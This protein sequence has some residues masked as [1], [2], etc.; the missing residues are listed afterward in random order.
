MAVKK[1]E[2]HH[3]HIEPNHDG[4]SQV[5]L[6]KHPKEG[7]KNR[8]PWL[9]DGNTEERLS[10]SSAEEAGAHVKKALADHFSGGGIKNNTTPGVKEGKSAAAKD[11]HPASDDGPDVSSDSF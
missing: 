1:G 4:S 9:S 6:H 3:I 7:R 10:A 8:G 11:S 2:L 5:V